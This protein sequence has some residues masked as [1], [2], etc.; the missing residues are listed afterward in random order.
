MAKERAHLAH[1]A[2]YYGVEEPETAPLGDEQTAD[3][4]DDDA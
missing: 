1:L 2:D 4:V 3:E